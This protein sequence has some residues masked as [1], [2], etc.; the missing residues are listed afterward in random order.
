MVEKFFTPKEAHLILPEIKLIVGD[1][2]IK[3]EESR[4]LMAASNFSTESQGRLI[5]LDHQIRIQMVRLEDMGCFYKD[6]NFDIGLV[7]FPA[8]I[9]G[10]Q[11]LMCWRSDEEQVS[12]F[13]GYEDGFAGRRPIT[14]E[15]IFS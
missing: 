8:I 4:T 5:E 3:A 13:H 11:A 14:P 7:D 15:L 9:H 12:W 2:L 6:W 10:Q 1:I